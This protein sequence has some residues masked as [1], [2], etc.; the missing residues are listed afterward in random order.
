MF[1]FVGVKDLLEESDRVYLQLNPTNTE[2]TIAAKWQF[3]AHWGTTDFESV[4]RNPPGAWKGFGTLESVPDKRSES[5]QSWVYAVPIDWGN[6]SMYAHYG[7]AQRLLRDQWN[8][9]EG[10]AEWQFYIRSGTGNTATIVTLSQRNYWNR[11]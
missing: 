10:P 6:I 5:G 3:Q 8:D 1:V 2:S 4:F 9:A 7:E 11:P